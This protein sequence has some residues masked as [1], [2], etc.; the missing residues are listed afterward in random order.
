LDAR[1]SE[2]L[3]SID[4]VAVWGEM[5]AHGHGRGE[6]WKCCPLKYVMYLPTTCP[7]AL[8]ID[9]YID[10][11]IEFS[12][13]RHLWELAEILKRAASVPDADSTRLLAAV[14]NAHSHISEFGWC[15]WSATFGETK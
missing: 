15:D 12:K 10:R 8:N 7:S 1:F 5:D 6:D 11:V 4:A 3:R 13:R 2:I 14:G 9:Y